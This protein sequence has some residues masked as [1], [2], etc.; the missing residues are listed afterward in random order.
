MVRPG[1]SPSAPVLATTMNTSGLVDS[2]DSACLTQNAQTLHD[3]S[4][5][6][7]RRVKFEVLKRLAR[8]CPA[9]RE[10]VQAGPKMHIS[11]QT[12]EDVPGTVPEN[13]S[14][15]DKF[16][17]LLLRVLQ[18]YTA[19]TEISSSIQLPCLFCHACR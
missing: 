1:R 10:H 13:L 16:M 3:G 14:T 15:L 11:L 8:R 7:V 9:R 5:K 19:A 6:F 12:A 4:L 18:S 17:P 2:S